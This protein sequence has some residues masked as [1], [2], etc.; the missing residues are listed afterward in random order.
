MVG[1]WGRRKGGEVGSQISQLTIVIMW[2]EEIKKNISVNDLVAVIVWLQQAGR[3][4]TN[5]QGHH[6]L[7][8][9][10]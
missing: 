9:V 10:W 3:S 4:M 1:C 6:G 7:Q 8:I 5:S 2:K